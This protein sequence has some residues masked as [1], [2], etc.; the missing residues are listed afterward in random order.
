MNNQPNTNNT[1][2]MPTT[3]II[4]FQIQGPEGND[5]S[6]S[7][8]LS[9]AE[10][11]YTGND[12]NPY[13]SYGLDFLKEAISKLT[14]VDPITMQL[15]IS[16]EELTTATPLLLLEAQEISL[17]IKPPVAATFKN[18]QDAWSSECYA[19]ERN[20][21]FLKGEEARRLPPTLCYI[22][23]PAG[24]EKAGYVDPPTIEAVGIYRDFLK[25]SIKMLPEHLLRESTYVYAPQ[26]ILGKRI[27]R[28]H[29]APH[30]RAQPT[31]LWLR[32][33]KDNNEIVETPSVQFSSSGKRRGQV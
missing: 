27:Q 28:L 17:M 12:S 5:L 10:K 32:F 33:D 7:I 20:I 4:E 2:E 6:V 8:P 1:I 9:E 29:E 30:H 22:R 31:H 19:L 15:F 14:G 18:L 26:Y 24:K 11:V 21:D 25:V 16:Q 3:S 13:D 23:S